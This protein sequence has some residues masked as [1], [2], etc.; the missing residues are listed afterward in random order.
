MIQHIHVNEICFSGNAEVSTVSCCVSWGYWALL[1]PSELEIASANY[2]SEFTEEDHFTCPLPFT[3][4]SQMH[5]KTLP[6]NLRMICDRCF[7]MEFNPDLSQLSGRPQ[8]AEFETSKSD[9]Q[10]S[11]SPTK[12]IHFLHH[13][14]F[15]ELEILLW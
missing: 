6:S 1:S 13:C 15:T 10:R 5:V 3:T 2:V 7:V 9:L 14:C 12:L 11:F 4:S 8:G